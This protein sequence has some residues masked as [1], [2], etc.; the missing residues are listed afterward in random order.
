[1]SRAPKNTLDGRGAKKTGS[2]LMNPV[3]IV[4][5]VIISVFAFAALIVL[6][7]YAD[8][9]RDK[10]NGRAHAF[11][12]SGIGF[13]GLSQLLAAQGNE[14]ILDRTEGEDDE[15]YAL[16][17]ITLDRPL[18]KPLSDDFDL[19]LPTLI[20]MPKWVTSRMYEHK[21]WRRI[22]RVPIGPTYDTVNYA[23]ALPSSAGEVTFD[24]RESKNTKY[25]LNTLRAD[26]PQLLGANI[27]F[28]QTMDG[29]NLERLIIADGRTVL[30]KIT[31]EPVYILSDP[32]FLNTLGMAN[33]DRARFAV[34]L[35]EAVSEWEEAEYDI[36]IFDLIKH[37]F[38]NTDNLIKYLLQPPFLAATLCLIAAGILVGWQA[39]SRFGDP[40]KE[41]PDYALGKSTLADNAARFI[42]IAGRETKMAPGY[43]DLI[44]RQASKDMN[45]Q[46]QSESDIN[47]VLTRR[48]EIKDLDKSWHDVT[49]AAKNAPDNM[50]LLQAARKLY[51]W[52]QEISNEHR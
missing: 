1:M 18:S 41:I 26:L 33:E 28:L 17:I 7:G 27:D 29:D 46:G 43:V 51:D 35:L 10:D 2:S 20:V 22:V 37:G 5:L 52:K 3:T 12:Q 8:N 50:S 42:K 21:G 34:N 15:P 49:N 24:H 47:S 23:K 4:S 16:K 36:F 30:A 44:R 45:L 19:S 13:A 14:I 32:D 38:G 11:S 6:S 48:G 40:E 25:A 39:F 31:D 9:W